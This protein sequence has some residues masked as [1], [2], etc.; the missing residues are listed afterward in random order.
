M[1]ELFILWAILH[2]VYPYTVFHIMTQLGEQAQSRTLFIIVGGIVTALAHGLGLGN[3][4]P[5]MPILHDGARLNLEACVHMEIFTMVGNQIWVNHH[6]HALFPCPTP[7][8]ASSPLKPIGATTTT[9]MVRVVMRT[10]IMVHALG[11]RA[12]YWIPMGHPVHNH[13]S[14]M[15]VLLMMRSAPPSPLAPRRFPSLV[16]LSRVCSHLPPV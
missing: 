9:L 6:S 11:M 2:K 13:R 12:Q 4:F 10:P 15:L 1:G 16:P 8:T 14:F 5:L 3:L 7:P